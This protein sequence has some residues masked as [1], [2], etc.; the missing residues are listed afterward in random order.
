MLDIKRIRENLE[1]M[2]EAAISYFTTERLPQKEGE[3]VTLASL[4][5]N[6]TVTYKGQELDK[7]QWSFDAE[8]GELKSTV[9]E[10]STYAIIFGAIALGFVAYR[11]RK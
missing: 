8:T 3:S 11:R 1:T 4:Q 10:P 9:P 6:M 2:K 5:D 7:S